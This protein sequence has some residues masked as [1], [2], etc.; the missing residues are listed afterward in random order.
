MVGETN[1]IPDWRNGLVLGDF[2]ACS[3]VDVSENAP[4]HSILGIRQRGRGASCLGIMDGFDG[5][6]GKLWPP[7]IS[8]TANEVFICVY[9]AYL[10]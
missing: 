5:F 4:P 8:L 6:S 2:H 1:G 10:L 9:K 3:S 7:W